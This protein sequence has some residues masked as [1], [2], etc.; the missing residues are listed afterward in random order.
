MIGTPG[1][2]KST[3]AKLLAKKLNL[4]HYSMGRLQRDIADEKGISIFELNKL[5]E[6]DRSLDEEVDQS[7]MQLGKEKDNFVI[8]SRL[9]FHFIPNSIKIFVDADFEERAKRVLS[10]TIRK[11]PNVNLE[12][13]RKNIEER[14]NSEKRRYKDYYNLNPYDTSNYDLVIDST[15]IPQEDVA[16]KII[17]FVNEKKKFIFLWFW[18]CFYKT[19]LCKTL[20]RIH[21]NLRTLQKLKY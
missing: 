12:N 18:G 13:T 16:D 21:F 9:G 20:K 11:E 8:D 15:N 5:E 19:F 4:E 17:E 14:Q 6:T 3:V 7:Q 10:D 2:G 1:S